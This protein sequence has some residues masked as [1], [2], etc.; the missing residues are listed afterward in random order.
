MLLFKNKRENDF[1]VFLILTLNFVMK[2]PN[3]LFLCVLCLVLLNFQNLVAKQ[4]IN[5]YLQEAYKNNPSINEQNNFMKI[6]KLQKDLDYAQN[7]D[8]QVYLSANYLF[9]PYFNNSNG[10]IN[11]NPDQT[12]IGYDVGITN[13]GLYSAL[14]NVEKNIFNNP[15]KNALSQQR[16]IYDS[17]TKNN[18]ELLKRDIKKQV[19]D[20][21]L[22]SYLSDSL[23]KIT[24]EL[25]SYLNEQLV[26][27]EELVEEGLA[28]QSDYLLLSLEIEN[29]RSISKNYLSQF[30]TNLFD[31][32]T[33]CGIKD[34]KDIEL[35]SLSLELHNENISSSLYKRYE[36][37]SLT[38]ANQQQ[39]FE[40]KY[41][42]QVSLFFNT[43]L[44]AVELNNIQRK[45]GV[46]GGINFSLPIFDGNQKSITQQQSKISI[47][48]IGNYKSQLE[49]TLKN[50]R[51]SILKK[52]KNLQNNLTNLSK[53]I[54]KY[55]TVIKI[56]EQEL[57]QGHISMIE[58]LTILK[59]FTDFKINKITIE[60]NLQQEINNFNFWN[61]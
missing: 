6:N 39:I 40:T 1:F 51:E 8:F 11:T 37:D 17:S 16:L 18:I 58:Y 22:Q 47:E 56:S 7:S 41:Q 50:Q 43:G 24:N 12:A 2:L 19:I 25:I 3:Y 59:N 57:K 49:V 42:P 35:D 14:F 48:T 13:G 38:I 52:I 36:I 26:I 45:F 31:L 10:I 20:Q 9:A 28:K 61:Y 32:N 21:Y 54:E 60:I 27:S 34:N 30:E 23:Y 53:Q 29:Q 55:N 15:L 44:N 5:Y 46:S 4:N 33:T